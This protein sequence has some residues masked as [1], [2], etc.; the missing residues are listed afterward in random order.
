MKFW[1]HQKWRKICEIFV[2]FGQISNIFNFPKDG[3]QG[4]FG[5]IEFKSVIKTE[6]VLFFKWGDFDQKL[7]PN[8]R[9]IAHTS[10]PM[11]PTNFS[12]NFTRE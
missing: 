7:W 4:G 12:L 3:G 9:M 6:L 1:K 2:I 11:T 5:F 10:S 8:S